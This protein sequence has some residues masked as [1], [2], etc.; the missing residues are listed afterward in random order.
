MKEMVKRVREEKGGFTLA[1]LLIVVAILLVLIAIAVP[2]FSGTLGNANAAVAQANAR[3]AKSEALTSYMLDSKTGSVT[4]YAGYSE[5]GDEVYFT[6][7]SKGSGTTKYEYTVVVGPDANDN[8]TAEV[9]QTKP[10]TTTPDK[11]DGDQS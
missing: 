2:V 6:E 3:S 9:T 11:G 10:E 8:V 1:E 5:D 4:Y 7:G